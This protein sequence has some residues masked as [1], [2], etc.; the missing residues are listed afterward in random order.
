MQQ[1]RPTVLVVDDEAAILEAFQV[2]LE[3]SFNV[4][5]AHNRSEAIAFIEN[6]T[7]GLVFLD[8]P[9][10][11][12]DGMDMLREIRKRKPN[13]KVIIQTAYPDMDSA[14]RSIELGAS[15]YIT[16]PFGAQEV[17]N[18]LENVLE[19]QETPPDQ[20]R[21][22]DRWLT[23]RRAAFGRAFAGAYAFSSASLRTSS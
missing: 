23:K 9:I 8:V 5:L 21:L 4:L 6:E 18:A 2:I 13:I 20:R 10:P 11:G 19:R 1:M 7:P 16:K 22:A 3:D 17:Q 15:D 12:T 14:L